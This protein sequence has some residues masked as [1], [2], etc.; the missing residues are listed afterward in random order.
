MTVLEGSVPTHRP[1][2]GRLLRSIAK[3]YRGHMHRRACR[4]DYER[5]RTF[6]DY[7]LRDI[8]ISRSQVEHMLNQ[9]RWR[10]SR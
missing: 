6:T 8:G 2:V 4:K 3:A 9:S 10:R 1:I 7:Q 5:L